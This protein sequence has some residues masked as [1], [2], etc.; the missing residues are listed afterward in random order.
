M[1]QVYIFGNGLSIAFREDQ[2]QLSALTKQVKQSLAALPGPR[3][4]D[5]WSELEQL[6]KVLQPDGTYAPPGFEGFAGP[7]ERLASAVRHL[8]GLVGFGDPTEADALRRVGARATRLYQQVVGAV[9]L[10]VTENRPGND[11]SVLEATAR[12]LVGRISAEPLE[13]FTLNYDAWLDHALLAMRDEC[14][15]TGD[16]FTLIDEFAGYELSTFKIGKADVR[17][18]PW[19]GG[20]Y[21]SA[22]RLLRLHHLHGCA[23]WI[24]SADGTRKATMEGLRASGL[25]QTWLRGDDSPFQSA[26]VLG[27]S[28]ERLVAREPF[29]ETYTA[30]RIALSNA[31]RLV[32]AGYGFGDVPLNAAVAEALPQGAELVVINPDPTLVPRV[33]ACFKRLPARIHHVSEGLPIGLAR[34]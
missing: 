22:G 26:L 9:L 20:P 15:D 13:V 5:T 3:G 17:T 8:G 19:R 16:A 21:E 12:H 33:A 32:I 4:S 11:H 6:V 31:D 1:K 2:F 30:L 25:F 7:L 23:S 34:L 10:A 28:K 18:F 24:R 14:K 29:D 27:D